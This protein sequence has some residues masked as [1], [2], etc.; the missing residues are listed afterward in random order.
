MKR[1]HVHV[2]VDEIERSVRFYSALF[3]ATPS[4]LKSDYAKW[5]LDDPRVNF[6]ISSRGRVAGLDHLGIQVEDSAELTNAYGRLKA[7]ERP[8]LE[9]GATTCCYAKSEK[10]WVQ[11]PSGIAWETFLT[12]GENT[13]Y[14]EDA[15]SAPKADGV[16]CRPE[17][18]PST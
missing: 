10:A 1:L 18:T 2:A 15:L 14:G 6:A 16:C 5:M 17:R 4:V 9:Q 8:I 7:A 11:D 13:T 3:G 12:R